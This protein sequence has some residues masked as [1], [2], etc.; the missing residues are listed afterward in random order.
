[1]SPCNACSCSARALAFGLLLAACSLVAPGEEILSSGLCGHDEKVCDDICVSKRSPSVGC[2]SASC[3][4]CEV[5]HAAATC[6]EGKCAVAA[7]ELG[8]GDCNGVATDGCETDLQR[9]EQHCGECDT[10]CSLPR[11]VAA[12]LA[13][14][15]VVTGCSAGY[16]ECDGDPATACETNLG[17]NTAHCGA[18]GAACT[19]PWATGTTCV[20]GVCVATACEPGRADCNTLTGDGC[21]TDV[22]N[23]GA[24]CG[25]CGIACSKDQTCTEGKCVKRCYAIRAQHPQA[26]LS[27]VP[28]GFGVGSGDFTLEVWLAVAPGSTSSICGMNEQYAVSAVSLGATSK[29]VRCIVLSPK[30]VGIGS[31]SA[32]ISGPPLT[33]SRWT[34]L[35]CVRSGSTLTLFVDG[36]PSNAGP[37]ATDLAELS[38]FS[39]G[40]PGYVS[41][42]PDSG[43]S[44]MTLGPLR[45][46]KTARYTAAFT[47]TTSWLIDADSVAQFLTQLPYTPG[48][49]NPLV[50]EAGGDNLVTDFGGFAPA[51]A[52]VGCGG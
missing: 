9:A 7:C 37:V 47:P 1:M 14:R 33:P 12:C 21:E 50:D 22:S 43:S 19:L 13:G 39:I 30:G 40:V 15:C 18:C 6:V 45:F 51:L 4:P 17:Q 11:T 35:A 44:A 48:S 3:V 49:T 52:G 28:V 42:T 2:A 38:P 23:D 36:Q 41:G 25:A 8:F 16:A 29:F 32:V 5:S 26:R 34:H 27:V 20:A 10:K 24:N 31:G 46:S